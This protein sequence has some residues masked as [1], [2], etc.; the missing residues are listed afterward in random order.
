MTGVG[1]QERI[2]EQEPHYT[3]PKV[4]RKQ[5]R[6]SPFSMQESR[7]IQNGSL[8]KVTEDMKELKS[9]V[10]QQNSNDSDW[11]RTLLLRYYFVA[12]LLNFILSKN[13][14]LPK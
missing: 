10:I 12:K 4:Q 3:I 6:H 8:I 11:A 2:Y 13:S 7:Q 5:I 1:S 9:S 14:I